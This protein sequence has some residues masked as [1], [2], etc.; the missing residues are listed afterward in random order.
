MDRHGALPLRG[1]TTT[2]AGRE[3]T[4]QRLA[5]WRLDLL[6][7]G[8]TS[9]SNDHRRQQLRAGFRA[10]QT[11]QIS[12]DAAPQSSHHYVQGH[13]GSATAQPTVQSSKT[14]AS[15]LR[16]LTGQDRDDRNDRLSGRTTL[17]I[18]QVASVEKRTPAPF[19]FTIVMRPIRSVRNPCVTRY[20]T[21]L[22]S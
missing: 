1:S 16:Q 7:R 8:F 15:R 10:W 21:R 11:G 2:R 4:Q 17:Q 22:I 20:D 19:Q 18:L 13:D 9:W 3:G 6:H 12:R 5:P 14:I